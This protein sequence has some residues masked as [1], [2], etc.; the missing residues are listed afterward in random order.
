[1]SDHPD[2]PAIVARG[3]APARARPCNPRAGTARNWSATTGPAKD[4]QGTAALRR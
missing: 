4:A 1:M 2:A 3:L